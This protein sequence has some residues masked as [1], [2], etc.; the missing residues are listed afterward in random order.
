MNSQNLG[1]N[2]TEDSFAQD[3][4]TIDD[5]DVTFHTREGDIRAVN[6]VSLTV[7]EGEILCIV[8]ESGSGKSV[9][10]KSIIDLLPSPP[11]EI[12]GNIYFKGEDLTHY[13]RKQFEDLRGSEIGMIFQDPMSS[14]NP[15]LTIGR[16]IK[17]AF[18]AKTDWN[19]ERIKK[20][21][22]DLLDKVGIPDASN[23]VSDHPDEFSGGMRQRVV[24]A[25]AIANQPDLLIAD[26][27]T[28][29][30]DVTIEAQIIEMIKNFKNTLNMSIIWITHDLGVVAEI[31]DRVAVMY[32]G[33]IVEL[34]SVYDIFDN[35]KHPYTKGLLRSIPGSKNANQRGGLSPISGQPPEMDN[36][37]S[38]CSF[39]P[40][41]EDRFEH[42]HKSVPGNFDVSTDGNGNHVAKCFLY[43]DRQ[44]TK[45]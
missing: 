17:E 37:P 22:I 2:V 20:S 35:P 9:T 27:P 7:K 14:L 28:T 24:I 23:R 12:T 42:C 5:L 13:S 6:G 18:K 26:E 11:A 3:I 39:H 38:G 33:K 44:M 40:R 25:I 10:V 31:A 29:A 36:I 41:C 16:Q 19:K 8:G 4:L 21:T 43:D 45:E 30:L 32:A 15:T 1:K 34:G